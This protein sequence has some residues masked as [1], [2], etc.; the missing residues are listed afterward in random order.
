MLQDLIASRP[1]DKIHTRLKKG[2]HGYRVSILS[3][4]TNQSDLCRESKAFQVG[5]NGLEGS[6]EFM[7]IVAIAS[8]CIGAKP[9]TS[10]HLKSDGACANDLASFSSRLAWRTD[11]TLVDV[12]AQVG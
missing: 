1:C 8:A 12:E 10:M 6:G 11:R 2:S 4:K 3:I 9:L 5:R 7:A